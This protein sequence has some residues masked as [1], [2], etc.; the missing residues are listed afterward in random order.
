M[1]IHNCLPGFSLSQTSQQF[2]EPR[3]VRFAHG[4]FAIWLDPVG[5]LDPQVVV[6]LLPEFTVGVDLVKHKPFLL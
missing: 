6:N 4:R 2:H 1:R 5:M 3:L